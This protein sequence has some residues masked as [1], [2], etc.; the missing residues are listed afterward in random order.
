MTADGIAQLARFM[1]RAL[2]DDPEAI[3]ID[4]KFGAAA[5]LLVVHVAPGQAG[6]L[7]GRHG[8][9]IEAVRILLQ[10]FGA[11]ENRRVHLEFDDP[12][13]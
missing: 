5:T 6:Q 10:A 13:A 4:S 7:I 12:K 11:K 9:N 2:V 1:I 3:R 8:R